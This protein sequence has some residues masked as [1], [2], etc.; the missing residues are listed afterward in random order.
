[1][2]IELMFLLQMHNFVNDAVRCVETKLLANHL[3]LFEN[4]SRR[5]TGDISVSCVANFA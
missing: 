3:P 4:F 5:L 2:T 1:M